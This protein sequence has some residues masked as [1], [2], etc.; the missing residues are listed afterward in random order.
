MSFDSPPTREEITEAVARQHAY[1]QAE[2]QSQEAGESVAQR[3]Y[4]DW[5][6]A[7]A[8]GRDV[9][10]LVSFVRD[11]A[12]T[13]SVTREDRGEVRAFWSY[14]S[15][16]EGASEPIGHRYLA[17]ACGSSRGFQVLEDTPAGSRLDS[18]QLWNEHVKDALV[19]DYGLDEEAVNAL[20]PEVWSTVSQRYAEAAQGPVVAFA[21]DIAAFSVLGKDE[22]PRLLAHEQVGKDNIRFPLPAPRHEHLPPEI[23]ALIA[24]DAMRAQVLMEDFDP[25]KSP[26]EFAA[27]L[28]GV[29]VPERLRDDH[30]AAL[31]RLQLADSYEELNAKAS[32]PQPAAVN[33]FLPGVAV[34]PVAMP[35]A[36]RGPAAG[37]G[38]LNPAA[39]LSLPTPMPVQQSAGVER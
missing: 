24:D 25:E 19:R 2:P 14:M 23:D 11:V 31:R 17:Q 22:L 39:A 4:T 20:A 18:Y 21:T 36:P 9:P 7:H 10:D 26:K 33:E 15:Q 32:A 29:D 35:A 6:E 27:K 3:I 13:G 30:Q 8:Q 34:R 37:H 28:G 12:G 38:V 1:R 16:P 5:R